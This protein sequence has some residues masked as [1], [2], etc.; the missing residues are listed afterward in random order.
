MYAEGQKN[1]IAIELGSIS[2]GITLHNDFEVARN[3][4]QQLIYELGYPQS[5]LDPVK[6]LATCLVDP[7]IWLLSHQDTRA[8]CYNPQENTTFTVRTLTITLET[9]NYQFLSVDKLAALRV[10]LQNH[11]SLKILL[12]ANTAVEAIRRLGAPTYTPDAP[13]SQTVFFARKTPYDVSI[14]MFI[15]ALGLNIVGVVLPWLFL[16]GLFIHLMNAIFCCCVTRKP[17]GIASFVCLL[18]NCFLIVAIGIAFGVTALVVY[19]PKG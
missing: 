17:G 13:T 8:L 10:Q 16:L 2:N 6:L 3:V 1:D 18:C 14:A 19:I 11:G 12:V 15:F 9:M 5:D 7:R 4:H